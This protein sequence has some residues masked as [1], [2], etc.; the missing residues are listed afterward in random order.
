MAPNDLDSNT[1]SAEPL[2]PAAALSSASRWVTRRSIYVVIGLTEALGASWGATVMLGM[3]MHL[4]SRAI[5][6]S[7]LTAGLAACG[8]VGFAGVSLL[9]DTEWG[10]AL[11]VGVQV[12][13]LFQVTAG[14]I[15][16]RF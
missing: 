16:F 15:A 3:L 7:D 5:P 10:E 4:R 6:W 14:P 13:Q 11:S 9:H 12:P 1:C 2:R 8:L